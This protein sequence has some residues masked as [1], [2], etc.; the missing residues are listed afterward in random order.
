MIVDDARADGPV[1]VAQYSCTAA[2]LLPSGGLA[3]SGHVST[4]AGVDKFRFSAGPD[5]RHVI[6]SIT[7]WRQR[8]AD[9][10]AQAVDWDSMPQ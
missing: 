5:G 6:S 9:E 4:V 10:E 1:V 7:S 3:P 8:F 2:Q